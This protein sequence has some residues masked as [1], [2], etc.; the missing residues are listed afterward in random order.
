V[1]AVIAFVIVSIALL[2]L[3][4]VVVG[5]IDATQAFTRRQ[6]ASER[7]DRWEAGQLSSRPTDEYPINR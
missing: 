6:T 3:L 2:G 1:I 4:A 5:V 7:R